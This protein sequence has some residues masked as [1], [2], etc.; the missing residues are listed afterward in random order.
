[1]KGISTSFENA[2]WTALGPCPRTCSFS[3]RGLCARQGRKPPTPALGRP[4]PPPRKRYS[5]SRR[6][7]APSPP[8]VSHWLSAILPPPPILSHSELHG[9]RGFRRGAG[10]ELGLAPRKTTTWRKEAGLF[11]N[12]GSG[13][14]ARD[15]CW[16]G[17]GSWP[18]AEVEKGCRCGG[19]GLEKV[20]STLG[21]LSGLLNSSCPPPGAL[22]LQGGGWVREMGAIA[23]ARGAQRLPAL[24]PPSLPVVFPTRTTSTCP[25]TSRP[26]SCSVGEAPPRGRLSG[27]ACS[28]AH[29]HQQP[30][31]VQVRAEVPYAGGPTCLKEAYGKSVLAP[32]FL[33][34]TFIT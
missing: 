19:P 10:R 15:W 20:G 18:E 5:P 11:L 21:P 1:M 26:A 34:V 23:R 33:C 24:T 22:A 29:C 17:P 28:F 7:R 13:T 12:G 6:S 4:L 32:C 14:P 30:G 2:I 3:S 9:G 16:A 8:L 31:A 27:E 25:S